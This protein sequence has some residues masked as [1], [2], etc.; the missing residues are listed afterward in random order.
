MRRKCRWLRIKLYD[1]ITS[2][3]TY[4]EQQDEP[5]RVMLCRIAVCVMLLPLFLVLKCIE[6][7]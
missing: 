4:D 3:K 1:W 5:D 7:I 2:G 6:D